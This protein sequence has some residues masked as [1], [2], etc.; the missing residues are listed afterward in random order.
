MQKLLKLIQL[1]CASHEKEDEDS[2][3]PR[4]LNQASL[5]LTSNPAEK[6]DLPVIEKQESDDPT[7][8]PITPESSNVKKKKR[9]KASK[10][11]KAGHENSGG[12]TPIAKASE[13]SKVTMPVEKKP[14]KG[15]LKKPKI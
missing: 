10:Q 13:E 14:L 8:T 5:D 7:L 11:K 4:H 15:I 2:S 9:K 6:S 3:Q 1:C 12:A